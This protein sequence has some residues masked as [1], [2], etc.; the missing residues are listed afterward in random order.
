MEGSF[1]GT[2]GRSSSPKSGVAAKATP[3]PSKEPIGK[4]GRKNR[5][6]SAK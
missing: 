5:K 2:Q 6:R 3:Q 4:R 1:S